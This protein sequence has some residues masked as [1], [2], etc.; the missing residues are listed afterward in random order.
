[1]IFLIRCKITKNLQIIL[2]IAQILF[3]L[4]DA[5]Y[6]IV[7]INGGLSLLH[8]GLQLAKTVRQ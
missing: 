2:S 8:A 1:M 4:G 5:A 7:V 3:P 6:N